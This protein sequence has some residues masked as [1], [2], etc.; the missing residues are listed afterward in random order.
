M[1]S[2]FDE[3]DSIPSLRSSMSS[4]YNK[5]KEMHTPTHHNKNVGKQKQREKSQKQPGKITSLTIDTPPIRLIAD[6]SSRT[7]ASRRQWVK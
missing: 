3:N 1:F 4:K 6:L 5:Y 2:K 7:I